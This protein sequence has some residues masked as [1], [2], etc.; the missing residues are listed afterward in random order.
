MPEDLFTEE[1][2]YLKYFDTRTEGN[3][4]NF[5][6]KYNSTGSLTMFSHLNVILKL[7]D[8]EWQAFIHHALL[9]KTTKSQ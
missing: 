1:E 2:F 4:S 9:L 3:Y 8:C 5:F 7:H 6:K